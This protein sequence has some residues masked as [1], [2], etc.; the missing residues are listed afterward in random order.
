MNKSLYDYCIENGTPEL[1][2]QWDAEVSCELTPETIPYGSTKKVRWR[3]EKGHT[4]LASPNSRTGT[5]KTGFP[6]CAGRMVLAGENDLQSQFPQVAKQWHHEKNGELTPQNVTAFS[7][8]KVW[9]RCELGHE[10]ESKISNRTGGKGC[11]YCT[12][13]KVL[14]GFND[15]ATT[16]PELAEQWHPTLNGDLTPEK[17]SRGGDRKVW[18]Q[19]SGGHVWQA[20]IFS[21]TGGK[22]GCPVCA[23]KVKDKY[24]GMIGK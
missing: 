20:Y 10:Y 7:N 9:W 19:C 16:N 3:C 1:L 8:R 17:V 5:K 24:A 13:K 21:R 11:P 18:W 4:W 2:R 22:T 15:L 23:G 14:A 6:V 12:G